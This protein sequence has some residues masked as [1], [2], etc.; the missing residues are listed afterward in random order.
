MAFE[1][2]K[3]NL[4][5]IVN[6]FV[7]CIKILCQSKESP[8][9]LNNLLPLVQPQAFYKKYFKLEEVNPPHSPTPLCKGGGEIGNMK[10]TTPLILN[11]QS[12]LGWN[13]L[14]KTKSKIHHACFTGY[15]F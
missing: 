12:Q 6:S 1:N 15:I 5:S 10:K 13:I 3:K 9:F 4:E 14:R 11:R 8:P 7:F 2:S